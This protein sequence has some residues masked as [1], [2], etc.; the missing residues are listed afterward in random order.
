MVRVIGTI[1]AY[2]G[3]Q[4][5]NASHIRKVTDFHELLFH[6]LEACAVT[7]TLE[8]GPVSRIQPFEEQ[9]G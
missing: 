3:R 8:R 7:L 1:K 5:I 2:G 9:V 4:Y 6:A